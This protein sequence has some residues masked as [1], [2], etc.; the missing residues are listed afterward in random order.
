MSR[1]GGGRAGAGGERGASGGVR[2][3]QR[4]VE[5]KEKKVQGRADMWPRGVSDTRRRE[6]GVRRV[7]REAGPDR[8]GGGVLSGPACWA[9]RV[10]QAGW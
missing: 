5:R 7:L 1:S 10:E 6:G 3:K 9:V 2:E 8:A 4:G